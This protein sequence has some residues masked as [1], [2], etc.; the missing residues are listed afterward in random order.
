MI[1]F[2]VCLNTSRLFEFYCSDSHETTVCHW[3]K[4]PATHC[5]LQTARYPAFVLAAICSTA[6]GTNETCA[7]DRSPGQTLIALDSWIILYGFCISH[8]VSVSPCAH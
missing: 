7:L 8:I 5:S 6:T 4:W 2:F 1:K 3:Y